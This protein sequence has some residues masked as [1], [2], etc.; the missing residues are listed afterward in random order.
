MTPPSAPAPAHTERDLVTTSPTATRT[1][2]SGW[3]R[4]APSVATL[5]PAGDDEEVRR[6]VL[7][8]GERGVLAR[9]LARSYG[10]SAQNGG[11]TVLDMTAADRVLS[12]D[13]T[14]GLVSAEAGVSLDTL[15]RVLLPL[16][17]FVPV[18]PGTRQVTLG[19]AVA[20][21]IHGKNHHVKGSFG[22]HVVSLDLL[23]ADGEVRRLTPEGSPRLF[24]ATVGGM[25][26]TGVVLRVTIRAVPVE[27]GFFAVDTERATD[28]DDLMSRLQADDDRYTYS[29]AWI[30]LVARGRSTGRAVL[31]RGWSARR[32]Q[33]PKKLVDKPYH[34]A[35]RSLFTAP[36]VFPSG[37]LNRATIS[38]FNEAYYRRAPKEQRGAIQSIGQFF[39]PLDIAKD[40][41]R[42]YGRRGFLQYQ[43]VVPFGQEEAMRRAVARLSQ[44]GTASFLA[45][46]KRFGPGNEGF[47]S[48]PTPGWTL[49]LD[50]PVGAGLGRLLDELDE[51]VLEAGG[52]LYLAKDSRATARTLHQ[53]YPRVD[54]WRAVRDEVD[55]RR[56]FTS[57][58]AKRLDL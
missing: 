8:A 39:H 7:G 30:D 1:A 31:T 28:L 47:L 41:N 33:L 13:T 45:V 51:L 20:A 50:I 9:G 34:F 57:D 35:P 6:A 56:V 4:T 46:L 26:L 23:T 2:L 16:G 18:L 22:N 3:G 19:G 52:R 36:D 53:M 15:V 21:D 37:L 40:W 49:A 17:L 25:G 43:F 29:V 11:G 42:V 12:I 32:D 27:T 24:W 48:F 14:T 54:E 58:Q 5:V 55:P 10:D 38:A 44:A